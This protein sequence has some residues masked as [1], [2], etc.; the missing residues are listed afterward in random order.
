V[1]SGTLI[2]AALVIVGF[3]VLAWLLSRRGRVGSDAPELTEK[4]V[5]IEEKMVA[6]DAKNTELNQTLRAGLGDTTRQVQ[7][8]LGESTK[9]VRDVTERLTKLD[10]TN[11]Q[12]INFADQL[13][14]LQ[15]ILQNP[16]HRG[17][18][19]EY[20]L[21]TVLKNVLPPGSYQMQY[22][23][24]D[25]EI[26]DAVVKVKDRL[27]PIDSKFSLEN[28][29]RLAEAREEA[30]RARLEKQ[31]VNDL[32]LRIQET[33]K[34]IRPAE[35]TTE[36]AFMFIPHEAIYYD[37]LVNKVGALQ[38][39][40]TENLIQRAA[41]KY[42]VIIISPTSFYAYLQTVLQGLKALEIEQS[43]LEIQKR[44]E[45]LWKHLQN[46]AQFVEKVGTK[47][48]ETRRTYDTAAGEF[49]KIETDVV[50]IGKVELAETEALPKPKTRA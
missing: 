4:L 10:E 6:L 26:V 24:A 41:G 34:Y 49:R 40:N 19:G 5:R 27:V 43:A 2:V 17:V 50:R 20:Y 22:R 29:N 12:V 45:Q 46:Y 16:K 39:E 9:I 30:E 23:F 11:R 14:K 18:L 36:F 1:D 31:F 32:K 8:Q 35:G 48:D 21:E 47:L 15:D 13:Q 25:G 3:A 44:V 33:A 38:T 37:L 7:T 42:R 28:Y